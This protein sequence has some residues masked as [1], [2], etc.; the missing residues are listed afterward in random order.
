MTRFEVNNW[1]KCLLLLAL[2]LQSCTED[3]FTPVPDAEPVSVG[4][5]AGGPSGA[6][7]ISIENSVRTRTVAGEDGLSTQWRDDD[8]I[9]LWAKD[10][11]GLPALE[12]CI[13]HAYG[14]SAD[15]AFFTAE[16]ASAM[17]DGSYSYIACCPPPESIR[18]RTLLYNVPSEQDGSCSDGSDIMI[19]GQ[20]H[21]GP[22]KPIDWESGN[23]D[24]LHLEMRHLMHR[25]RFICDSRDF[26]G[27]PIRKLTA[28][29]PGEVTGTVEINLDN[30]QARITGNGSGTLNIENSGNRETLTAQIVPVSFRQG[31]VLTV[32]VFT[33]DKVATCNIPLN[34]RD[35]K[36]G[37]STPIRVK[38]VNISDYH[39]L[40]F[41]LESNHLGEN[42]EI[43]SISAPQGCR[44]PN[45]GNT[46][47]LEYGKDISEENSFELGFENISDLLGFS[48]KTLTV[49]Y[50]SEHAIVSEKIT[51]PDLAGV[52]EQTVSLNV[53]YL[54]EEDFHSVDSFSSNDQYATLVSGSKDAVGFLNGWTGARIGAE[55][56]TAIRIACRRETS[57]DYSARVDS[58]PVNGTLKS[59]AVL[60]V[61]FDY[62][63][64]EQHGGILA[65]A[66][67]Q[68]CFVGYTTSSDAYSSGSTSGIFD[69][70]LNTFY[71]A[72][73]TGSYTNTPEHAEML[74]AVDGAPSMLRICIRTEIE[75]MSGMN[76]STNWL[77]I[78]NVKVSLGNE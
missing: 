36:E 67:G 65:G 13:F 34:G 6:S 20:G 25:L 37:H 22:L 75:H 63:S 58:A 40:G 29:F 30:P 19:S 8:A 57:A 56:G 12:N 52:P 45:G 26:G 69:R 49:T 17:Q 68:N 64:A 9:S 27:K 53:P 48:G 46:L 78:D 62:G 59:G 66:V 21:S 33:S 60:K 41:V 15:G 32:K 54:L 72:A 35:F 39:S 43:L 16:L 5:Y 74:L 14:I 1:F 7:G 2:S 77:Y 50:E 28:V 47:K 23:R 18:G 70:S 3:R 76:N 4:F 10:S 51:V 11:R 42:P 31:D 38:P 44:F 55:K 24:F 73:T 71:T 61:E